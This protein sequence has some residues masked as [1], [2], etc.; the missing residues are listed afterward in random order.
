MSAQ[1]GDIR[2]EARFSEKA[3]DDRP[4]S[5][6]RILFLLR[7]TAQ[8]IANLFLH[9]PAMKLSAS[10]QPGLHGIFNIPDHELSHRQKLLFN[11]LS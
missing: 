9:A 3:G 2:I 6:R 1:F 11:L 4:K 8:Y 10:L 7:R 5:T